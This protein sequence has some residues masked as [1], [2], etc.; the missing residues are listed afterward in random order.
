M[1]FRHFTSLQE[2]EVID[3][4]CKL[5]D[6]ESGEKIILDFPSKLHNFKFHTNANVE[7][8]NCISSSLTALEVSLTN[9]EFDLPNLEKLD[10]EKAN[11]DS[12]SPV[13]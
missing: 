1:F 6:E 3:V 13:L 5:S 11:L 8:N 7:F 9:L 12:L 2:L 10:S 4:N